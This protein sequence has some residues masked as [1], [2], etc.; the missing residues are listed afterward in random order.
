VYLYS[1]TLRKLVLP[2]SSG[3]QRSKLGPLEEAN[4][5][6]PGRR[7]L[8]KYCVFTLRRRKMSKNIQQFYGTP[9]ENFRLTIV[10][11][12]KFHASRPRNN[13]QR[14]SKL[15]VQLCYA[16]SSKLSSLPWAPLFMLQPCTMLLWPW[17]MQ[18]SDGYKD[19]QSRRN[20]C[21][22][23]RLG[24]MK[25]TGPTNMLT[26]MGEGKRPP[27]IR[28]WIGC[29]G[30]NWIQL[31]R[32]RNQRQASVWNI[33]APLKEENFFTSWVTISHSRKTIFIV[34]RLHLTKYTKQ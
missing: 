2:P 4:L 28:R 5:N 16:A 21:S 32:D 3:E 22:L 6:P 30:V 13:W 9:S 18:F 20:R 26:E 24:E 23:T 25:C 14:G 29:E 17:S 11:V 7:Q 10:A 34:V 15:T 19:I 27:G 1:L 33:A 12:T 31:A 8:P